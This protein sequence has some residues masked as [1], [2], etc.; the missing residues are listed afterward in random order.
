MG[1]WLLYAGIG[2][3]AGAAVGLGIVLSRRSTNGVEAPS[4][5][6]GP[7]PG[8]EHVPGCPP[9]GYRVLLIGDSYAQGL[10]PKLRDIAKSCVTP[11]GSTYVV[12]S[13][14]TEW[15]NDAWL[16]PAL[17]LLTPPPNVVLVS[18][19]ANDFQRNDPENVQA[20][21]TSLV[22]K[23]RAAGCRVL[24]VSPLTEPFEDKV[25][26]RTMWR[27]AVPD[28]FDSTQIDIPRTGDGIHSTPAGY[29]AWAEQVWL[30]A[31]DLL[32]R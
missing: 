15:A 2:A 21:V 31:S 25:G 24:W 3:A 32:S 8:M 13:H 18:L 11:F 29:A 17:S 22:G 12:G 9:Q 14:V 20:G 28:W 4:N 10:T 7:S 26:V 16:L 30:W 23:L 27:A 5:D 6:P 19:G 1:K